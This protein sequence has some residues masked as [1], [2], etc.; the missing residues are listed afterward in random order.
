MAVVMKNPPINAGGIRDAGSTPG[1]GRLPGERHS[2]PFQYSAL[3]NP[4]DRGAQWATLHSV[5]KNW[6]D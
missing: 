3:E 1:S 4:T 2:N 5:T 6:T